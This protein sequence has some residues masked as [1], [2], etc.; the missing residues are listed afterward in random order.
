MIWV[1]IGMAAL[2]AVGS[3]LFR[4]FANTWSEQYAPAQIALLVFSALSH[5]R[6]HPQWPWIWAACAT[7]MLSLVFRTI[8]MK[9]CNGLPLGSHFLWHPL[10][11]VMIALLLQILLRVDRP[12]PR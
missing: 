8:D 10:I 11:G 6:A 12:L 3:F 2:I 4:T 9:V 7:F 1:L 5:R